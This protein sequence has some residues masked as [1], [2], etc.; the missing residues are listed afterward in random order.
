MRIVLLTAAL[1]MTWGSNAGAAT[2]GTIT[3]EEWDAYKQSFVSDGRVVD[4]GNG[5]ISHSEGQG[6]GM[7]LSF[8][9]NDRESF[10]SIWK[11]TQ[12][13]LLVRDDSLVAWKWDPDAEPHVTDNNNASD[14]DIL[15]AYALALAGQE[16]GNDEYTSAARTIAQAVGE[17]STMR[18]R[19]RDILL[20]GSF[21]FREEDLDDGPVINLSY[22]VFEAF[23]VLSKV[24][25]SADW[26]SIAQNGRRFINEIKFGPLELP[27]D[28]VSLGAKKPL[29]AQNFVPEFGYNSVRIPLY[30]MRA[31]IKEP[32][33]LKQFIAPLGGFDGKASTLLVESGSSL[34]A[35]GEPGYIVIGAAT[36]C[37]LDGRQIAPELLQF[38]P[39][40]YYGSTL[41][42]LTLSFLRESAP[43][44]L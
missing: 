25:P 39:Q 44:C 10:G 33:L 21:G 5:N 43:Q 40:S 19:G 7:F 36:A 42:L 15:I 9:A 2:P 12:D 28:W 34:D 14:G 29:P 38:T 6:Y 1:M 22:W 3:P 13:E 24:A 31:G 26:D 23:P 8:L 4:T 17:T 27:T 16:W 37:I 30:L 18:W 20:P 35:L 41:H 11:F 32:A